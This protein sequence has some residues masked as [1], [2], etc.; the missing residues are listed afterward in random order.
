MPV[1]GRLL[2]RRE[3]VGVRECAVLEAVET[4]VLFTAHWVVSSKAEPQSRTPLTPLRLLVSTRSLATPTVYLARSG[5]PWAPLPREVRSR[6][7]NEGKGVAQTHP[8]IS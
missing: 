6:D 2:D 8:A 1:G 3:P 5:L 4:A 7:S